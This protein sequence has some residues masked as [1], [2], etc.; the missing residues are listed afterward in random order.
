MAWFLL[1]DDNGADE[2]SIPACPSSELTPL[3]LATGLVAADVPR[4]SDTGPFRFEVEEAG[5][6]Q[7]SSG[8]WLVVLQTVMT[9]EHDSEFFGRRQDRCEPSTSTA[10]RRESPATTT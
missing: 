10:T 2:S 7:R 1:R 3:D 4:Y 9:N 5:Y 8:S 6:Q